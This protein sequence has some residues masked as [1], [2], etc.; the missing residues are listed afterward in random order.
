M[1]KHL[2]KLLLIVAMMVVPWVTQAQS[3][4]D[5]AFSTGTDSTAWVTLSSSATA[6]T[7]AYDD[8]SY[9]SVMSIGFTFEFA[10]V[11]YTQWSCNS[12]G[13]VR[14]GSTC[15]SE[16]WVNPFTTA[17]LTDNS[18]GSDTP[19]IS[20]FGMDNTLAGTGVWLKYEV[21]GTA[22]NRMLVIEYRTPSEYDEYGDLVNYQIQLE[23]TTNTVRFVYGTTMASYYDPFQ[24]GMATSATD[25]V[26][27][28]S[29]HTVQY[30]ATSAT[31]S[32][33]PGVYRYY[34]FSASGIDCYRPSSM[35][36]SVTGTT[37]DFVWSDANGSEWLL[38]WGPAGMNPD[39]VTVNAADLYDTSYTVYDLES[40]FYEAYVRTLCTTD[41]SSWFGPV[42]FN[43]GITV[44]N[45]ATSGS[46]TLRSCTALIYDDGG[47]TGSYSNS[48]SS[49]ILVLYPSDSLHALSI[50]GSSYTESTYD[51]L[52]FY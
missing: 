21:V 51:Y 4:S 34:E 31:R 19:L 13:R 50:S 23:E 15:V 3:L 52:R 1:Q 9:S 25:V 7:A 29:S 11:S 26:T 49:S 6:V 22:P 47:P 44:M 30:G 20:A 27:V 5:Y 41:S 46:D 38:V 36:A 2:Q 24:A 48:I 12:N 14:L 37:A 17:S 16:Y 35:T 40:G 18:Y 10:G 39:T 42:A 33:W 32:S 43:V 45:M 8:D 28:S